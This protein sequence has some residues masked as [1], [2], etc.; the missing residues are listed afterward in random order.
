LKLYVVRHARALPRDQWKGHDELRPLDERGLEDATFLAAS[1]AQEDAP[2][3]LLSGPTLRCQQTL[4]PIAVAS[5]LPIEVDD[6]LAPGEVAARIL[7]LLPTVDEGPIVFCTHSDVIDALLSALELSAPEPDIDTVCR[8]GAYWVLEGSGY[9]PTHARYVEPPHRVRRGGR[10]IATVLEA[11]RSVRAAV[12]DLGSTS[13]NL[14]IADVSRDGEI[15]PVIREKVMLRLGAMIAGGGRI[16]K[17]VATVAVET[18]AELFAVAQREKVQHLRPVATAALRETR[19]GPKVALAIGKVL[20]QPVR[21]LSGEEEARAIFRAMR[22]R[23]D[24]GPA[25]TLGIDLGGGSLELALGRGD[26]VEAEA[27][28]RL[29]AVRLHAELVRDDPMP[30]ADARAIRDRVARELAPHLDRFR[31]GER[32]RAVVSGGTARALARVAEEGRAERVSTAPHA[33]ELPLAELERLERV[34]LESRHDDRLQMRGM[35]RNRADLVPTGAV[36]L[37]ALAHELDLGGFTVC[38][39][40][41]REGVLLEAAE[42]GWRPA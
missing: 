40:G 35:R 23:I 13:F 19:N 11:P 34:L 14:L 1:L 31:R 33:V 3:R 25:P 38:D 20:E 22:R 16:P 10:A 18:A 37:R 15:T 41:L 21:I 30:E 42:R 5:R 9:T 12:L 7:E 39:W 8:K 17:E 6:R 2:V 4:E 29:G 27:S 32:V 28:L 24:L 36:I 26:A